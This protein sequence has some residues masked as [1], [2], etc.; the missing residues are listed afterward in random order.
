MLLL[1][2]FHG[3]RSYEDVTTHEGTTI[4]LHIQ[5]SVLGQGG[6][7]GNDPDRLVLFV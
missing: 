4:I 2:V 1:M 5:G 3:A 7:M 6:L